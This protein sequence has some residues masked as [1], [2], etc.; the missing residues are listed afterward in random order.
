MSTR[1]DVL[2]YPVFN[3]PLLTLRH[4]DGVT[5]IGQNAPNTQ[6]THYMRFKHNVTL[7]GYLIESPEE[8]IFY[9]LQSQGP[10][11]RNTRDDLLYC[12]NIINYE[13]QYDEN[14]SDIKCKMLNYVSKKFVTQYTK[15]LRLVK[16][17][18]ELREIVC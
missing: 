14:F 17:F 6:S 10:H 13:Y 5:W 16:E 2:Y 9:V 18:I 11:S 3:L 12:N 8:R 7:R 4:E 1:R 15:E